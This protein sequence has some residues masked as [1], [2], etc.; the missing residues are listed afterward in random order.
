MKYQLSNFLKVFAVYGQY[1]CACAKYFLLTDIYVKTL[2]I[3]FCNLSKESQGRRL[4]K[5]TLV[6]LFELENHQVLYMYI[7]HVYRMIIFR[8]SKDINLSNTCNDMF[9]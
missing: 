7:Y 1:L 6:M 9:Y 5:A 8:C 4:D 3:Q 2:S